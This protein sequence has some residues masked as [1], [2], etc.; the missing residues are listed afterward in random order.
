MAATALLLAVP[1]RRPAGPDTLADRTATLARISTRFRARRER[2]RF[3]V[4]HVTFYRPRVGEPTEFTASS[5]TSLRLAMSETLRLTLSLGD[6][7]DSEATE[8]GAR[9]DNA[10]ALLFGLRAE[11]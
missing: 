10:G 6:E 3:G 2:E 4:S 7:Y 9:S 5:V 1:L 11:F 8:R